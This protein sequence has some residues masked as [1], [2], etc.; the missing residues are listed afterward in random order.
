MHA[1]IIDQNA[2]LLDECQMTLMNAGLQVT[3]TRSVHVAETCIQ[4]VGV[5]L[6]VMERM[7]VVDALGDLLGLAEDRNPNLVTVLRTQDVAQDQDALVPHFASL[8]CVIGLEVLPEMAM[9]IGLASLRA[10]VG[11][12]RLPPR[13]ARVPQPGA[14]ASFCFASR[15]TVPAHVVAAAA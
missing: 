4:R 8:H 6:L 9:I 14:N 15:R 11:A 2:N 5:D 13:P 1:L 7:T 10:Q 3:G 12:A